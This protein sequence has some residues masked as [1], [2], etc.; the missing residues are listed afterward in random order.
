M[1]DF[2]GLIAELRL[3]NND[4]LISEWIGPDIKNSNEYVIQID[5]T[6]LGLPSRD[7]FLDPSNTKYIEAY[8]NYILNVA[9]LLGASRINAAK[10]AEDIVYFEMQLAQVN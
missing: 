5:Q 6:S 10:E 8:K 7:Y 3:Y 2:I 1:F 4:I 9:T